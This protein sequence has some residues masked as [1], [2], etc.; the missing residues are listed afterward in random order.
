MEGSGAQESQRD[1]DVR[2]LFSSAPCTDRPGAQA[3]GVGPVSGSSAAMSSH[4]PAS[5]HEMPQE[6][7]PEEAECWICRE[8][9]TPSQ[10]LIQPCACRG[11][12]S[13]VHAACVEQWIAHHRSSSIDASAE[14]PSCPVCRRP[15][16]GTVQHPGLAA[17]VWQLCRRLL[18]MLQQL[19]VW[20][21]L[22]SGFA[23]TCVHCEGKEYD[24]FV[25]S[26]LTR[27]PELARVV[28]SVAFVLGA[29]Y[30][31]LVLTVSL[32][33]S[34]L[35]PQH[36]LVR[37]FH[38][39]RRWRL[40]QHTVDTLIFMLILFDRFLS[41]S[42]T[43]QCLMPFVAMAFVPYSKCLWH[44]AGLRRN[45]LGRGHQWWHCCWLAAACLPMLL[46]KLLPR[47]WRRMFHP[48][49]AGP[50]IAAAVAAIYMCSL[51]VQRPWG[52]VMIL[53][54]VHGGLA[55][56]GLAEI[57]LWR[58]LL[59][60]KD[61]RWVL[62]V[63]LGICG[64]FAAE[65]ASP[66]RAAPAIGWRFGHLSIFPAMQQSATGKMVDGAVGHPSGKSTDASHC[67]CMA[68]LIAALCWLGAI[69]GLSVAVNWSICLRVYRIWQR[70]HGTFSLHTTPV[71]SA[72]PRVRSDLVPN[73]EASEVPYVRLP[74]AERPVSP[75][76][77]I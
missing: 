39:A 27:V 11:S 8:T 2:F 64:A 55:I 7:L 23:M 63:W 42:L 61:M 52:P 33:P 6:D 74:D 51:T 69:T 1:A 4:T 9:A 73:M 32:P 31:L 5:D 53:F 38:V 14:A 54:A 65:G 43:V 75:R 36:W 21:V 10:P 30:T 26:L 56:L 3:A 29:A 71:P 16:R 12:M 20:L 67:T 62:V 35:P 44:V 77:F 58:R 59:W 24:N 17:F 45:R 13:G 19:A 15:Y 28:I 66:C 34:G 72:L 47:D 60:Q 70:R 18:F 37:Q 48:L 57:L 41:G 46:L 49:G 25:D 40:L 50:H 68:V 22:C 76:D